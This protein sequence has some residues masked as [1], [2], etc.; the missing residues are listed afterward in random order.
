MTAAVMQPVQTLQ[1]REQPLTEDEVWKILREEPELAVFLILAQSKHIL[2]ALESFAGDFFLH[3]QAGRR[4]W[5]PGALAGVC[6]SPRS[7]GL[8]D[9]QPFGRGRV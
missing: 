8:H 1:D 6:R 5:N 2:N 7:T 4:R 9:A 3:L